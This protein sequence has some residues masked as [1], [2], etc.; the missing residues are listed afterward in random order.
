MVSEGS[1]D[2]PGARPRTSL[3]RAAATPGVGE[4]KRFLGPERTGWMF[5]LAAAA[6]QLRAGNL[7]VFTGLEQVFPKAETSLRTQENPLTLSLI[8]S[9]AHCH[10]PSILLC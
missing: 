3:E 9:I 5:T 1:S 10:N 4:E 6:Y 8:A 2:W 7:Q